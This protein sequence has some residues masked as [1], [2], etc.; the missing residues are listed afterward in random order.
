MKTFNIKGFTDDRRVFINGEE[1]LPRRSQKV[2]NHS[3]DGFSWG[4]G[5]SGPSQ[6]ALAILLVFYG[7]GIAL[8]NHQ[9]FK[10]KVIAGLD[11]DKDFD[12]DVD[13]SNYL[14]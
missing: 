2:L 4:Y 3:P 13:L 11:V 5:G 7:E 1:L 8:K 10:W 14:K 6:L 9:N 12:I